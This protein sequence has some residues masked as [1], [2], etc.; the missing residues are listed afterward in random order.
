MPP[1][2][3]IKMLV[4]ETVNPAAVREPVVRGGNVWIIGLA[5]SGLT[6]SSGQS[7]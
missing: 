7:T 5:L 3:L 6:S 4:G 2:K 1:A